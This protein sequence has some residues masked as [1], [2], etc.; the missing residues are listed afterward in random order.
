MLNLVKALLTAVLIIW[1][2]IF[3][4][5]S[6]HS[7]LFLPLADIILII[8]TTYL[9]GKNGVSYSESLF[10]CA[11][12][13]RIH[14]EAMLRIDAMPE[15]ISLSWLLWCFIWGLSNNNKVRS[16]LILYHAGLTFDAGNA[17]S[18]GAGMTP[19]WECWNLNM[20]FIFGFMRDPTLSHVKAEEIVNKEF[21]A[22]RSTL[23]VNGPSYGNAK[24]MTTRSESE[25]S[26][27]NVQKGL[28]EAT[29][30]YSLESRSSSGN[31]ISGIFFAVGIIL[32]SLHGFGSN[33]Y[34]TCALI[35]T[36]LSFILFLKTS[37]RQ[38]VTYND[39]LV[40]F[41]LGSVGIC[42]S[43]LYSGYADSETFEIF[44]R[45][46]IFAGGIHP[47][48]LAFQSMTL[49]FALVSWKDSEILPEVF[50]RV[51]KY[52]SIAVF[53][54]VL[55]GSGGRITWIITIFSLVMIFFKS[56]GTTVDLKFVS[57]FLVMLIG[58]GLWKFS[59]ETFGYE[60]FRNERFF[61]WKAALDNIFNA[62]LSGY[63]FLSFATLPQSIAGNAIFHVQDWN[64]PHSHNAYSE[65]LLT[66]GLPL[67][68]CFI[69]FIRKWWKKNSDYSN[70]IIGIS[71]LISAFFDF[72]F[73]Y[74]SILM[75]TV[76]H[77]SSAFLTE[78]FAPVA[79]QLP[80]RNENKTLRKSRFIFMMLLS[81]AA[82]LFQI[83]PAFSTLLFEKSIS[84]LKSGAPAWY[85]SI[86][87]AS[88]IAP[89]RIDLHLQ[90]NLWELSTQAGTL[91]LND[92]RERIIKLQKTWK[93]FFLLDY[94]LGRIYY[95]SGDYQ[96][97]KE[98]FKRSLELEPRD[99]KGIRWAFLALSRMYLKEDP[100]E[101]ASNAII[102]SD[103]GSSIILDHP[104]FG[105]SVIS[106]LAQKLRNQK[107][108]KDFYYFALP[109]IERKEFFR[110]D[111]QNALSQKDISAEDMKYLSRIQMYHQ[112]KYVELMSDL[113]AAASSSMSILDVRNLH[114]LMKTSEKT[115]NR[116][117]F[118]AAASETEKKWIYRSKYSEDIL[119]GFLKTRYYF[120]I[121]LYDKAE[122]L[123]LRQLAIDSANPWMLELY[124]DICAA[125]G[126]TDTAVSSWNYSL[127]RIRSAR[128]D[129]F[130]ADG[131]RSV[132]GS[133]GDQWVVLY[134]H[135]FRA[136]CKDSVNYHSEKWAEMQKR[137]SEKL[138]KVE[139]EQKKK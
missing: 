31:F 83:L 75:I 111:E 52:L 39:C 53:L 29:C 18:I 138:M 12:S 97:A 8:F 112:G 64:Y 135:A 70:S 24:D 79:N 59:L 133:M 23:L 108:F 127:K 92:F 123:L 36:L 5:D 100:I 48:A 126:K 34:F 41:S 56:S 49:I 14:I 17:R 121:N 63:G 37:F 115:D 27:E 50:R 98:H 13:R 4:A 35:A 77:F 16:L 120:R 54:I 113:T 87:R 132:L 102:R 137:I 122:E 33:A 58:V 46:R 15:I 11:L 99:M 106:I 104:V 71:I 116:E 88:A 91:N 105:K 93:N 28:Q 60:I 72:P 65:L 130:F 20:L 26:C 68:F 103:W 76:F 9:A 3:E 78:S 25:L 89:A 110:F 129:P 80:S 119:S 96:K 139:N 107:D 55:L 118:E 90:R 10:A 22:E 66:G 74:P 19:G 67:V 30:H 21:P 6:N 101:D 82:L 109:L 95:I 47:N 44:L 43:A 128:L 117:I 1:L 69:F 94:I 86:C 51:F 81:F 32:F 134:E 2:Y 125:S 136:I 40:A 73:F 7:I 114:L 131:A 38:G 62:P 124:G 85:N 57:A 45:K 42:I 61:I 84:S